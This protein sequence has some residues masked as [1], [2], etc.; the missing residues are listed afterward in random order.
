MRSLSGFRSGCV[1]AVAAFPSLFRRP[2]GAPLLLL[3]LLAVI[4]RGML[5]AREFAEVLR[6]D[7]LDFLTPPPRAST[8]VR[9]SETERAIVIPE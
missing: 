6:M 7:V 5:T 8:C 9:G 2:L 4:L 3:L 1:V